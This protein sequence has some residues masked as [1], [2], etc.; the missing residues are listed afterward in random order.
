[1][2]VSTKQARIAELAKQSKERKLT[3]LNYFIDEEWLMCAYASTR[4]D[5]APGIDEQTAKDY[6]EQLQKNLTDLL[7]R[8]KSGTYR[9]PAVRRATIP[10]AGGGSRALGIPTFEDKVAQRAIAMLLEPIYEVDFKASSYGFR[11]GKSAHMALQSLR[12]A[13]MAC[14]GGCWVIDADIKA[15]FDTIDHGCLREMLDK[16]VV[17]GVVRRTIDKWLKAGVLDGKRYVRTKEGTPQGGVISPLLANVYLHYVL[18]EWFA[19]EVQPRLVGRSELIRYADDFVMVFEEFL[20]CQRVMQVLGKR[21]SRYGLTLH[22]DKTRVIEFRPPWDGKPD[23]SKGQTHF[24]FLGFT[25]VWAKSRK[26]KWNVQQTTSK[27]SY[28]KA[29]EKVSEWCRIA[30]HLKLKDQ[31]L[32]LGQM[33]HGHYAYFGITGNGRRLS[34]YANQV[35]QIWRKWLMRRT[36]GNGLALRTFDLLLSLHPLP[37]PRIVHSYLAAGKPGA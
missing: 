26:G 8:L 29:L 7:E 21:L 32:R 15:Y 25:H 14:R 27:R 3:S 35:E 37:T 28:A 18:D 16:R 11:P 13:I 34:W 31:R 36:R 19:E 10:K 30:R 33:M 17:D 20:D 5:G 24:N 22:P 2:N 12:S 4:K 23:R 9:A 6:Q 1:M